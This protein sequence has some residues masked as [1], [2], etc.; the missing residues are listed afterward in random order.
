MGVHVSR[1]RS[2]TLDNLGTAELLVRTSW[3]SISRLWTYSE[4]NRII[5][6]RFL[7]RLQKPLEMVDLMK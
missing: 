4:Q 3:F 1:V 5:A 7:N 6:L 2:L